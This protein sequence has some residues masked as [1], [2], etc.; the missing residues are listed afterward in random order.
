ML[1]FPILTDSDRYRG[2]YVFD[3]GD[4]TA[5]GYTAEEIAVLLDSERYRDG[6]VY[7]IERVSPD[8]GMELRGVA[9]ERFQFESGLFFFRSS[10]VAAERDFESLRAAAEGRPAP[11]RAIVQLAERNSDQ[12][13]GFVTVLI[14]PAEHDADVSRWL[15][16]LDY[17][18]GDRVEGGISHVTD[19]YAESKEVLKRAQL[20]SRDQTSSRSRD[21]IL[22]SVRNALQR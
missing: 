13:A 6:K 1:K 5:T 2:L 17:Q 20:W 3:F 14:Y 16:D 15:L 12:E 7:R 19:Y 22:G 18:G 11:C 8:G 4:W 21:E 9:P 10:R